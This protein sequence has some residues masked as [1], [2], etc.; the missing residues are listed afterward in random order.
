MRRLQFV[1]VFTFCSLY[2]TQPIQP[3]LAAEFQLTHFQALGF[4]T[5]M[6]APLGI[7]P[8]LYG[9]VL[10]A[11]SAKVL[12][13]WALVGLGVLNLLFACSTSAVA[14]L[15][16]RGMQGCIFPAIITSVVSY[17]SYSSTSDNMQQRIGLYIGTTIF[18]GFFG[19]FV[20][21]LGTQYFGWRVFFV[22]LG[23]L[24]LLG[25]WLLRDMTR[26]VKLEYKRPNASELLDILAQPSFLFTYLAIFCLF[27]VFAAMMNFLPFHVKELYPL[28]GEGGVGLLYLGYLVGM[29]IS[30]NARR[31]ITWFGSAKQAIFAGIGLIIVGCLFF[32]IEYYWI[33]FFAM[34]IFCCG[35]FT[36]H[37]LL[38]GYVNR[39][40]KDNKAIANGLYISFYYLGGTC[41]SFFPEFLYR[42]TGWG[43]FL[44]LLFAMLALSFVLVTR[45]ESR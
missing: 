30:V 17:I 9:Y 44:T 28:K 8:L 4:T 24:L 15:F 39:I 14:L 20:S 19:R 31:L 38:T 45:I 7:A 43:G 42:G 40:A 13:R 12:L 11:F 27:F 18:G 2:A 16:I 35:F 29:I 25:V 21:G 3:L 10:E 1:T 26:D 33:L 5:V 36:V 34:F 32:L 22:V 23:C 6:M 41:G 37:P